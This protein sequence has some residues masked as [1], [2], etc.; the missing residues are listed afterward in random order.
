MKNNSLLYH[1]Y[2]SLDLHG[3]KPDTIEFLI[4]DFINDQIKL[5]NYHIIIVHGIGKYII[6]NRLYEVLANNKNVLHYELTYNNIGSTYV[7][8]RVDK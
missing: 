5:K 3:E 1:T 4:N 7:E 6:K 8:L 2:P